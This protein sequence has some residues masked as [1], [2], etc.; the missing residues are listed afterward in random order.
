V[1]LADMLCGSAGH[2]L[3]FGVGCASDVD[4]LR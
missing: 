3:L 1:L 4:S 2:P